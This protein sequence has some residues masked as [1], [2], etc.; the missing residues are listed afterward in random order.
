MFAIMAVAAGITMKQDLFHIVFTTTLFSVAIQGGLLPKVANKLGVV[1]DESDVRKTFNDYQEE[2]ALQLMRMYIPKG[3]NWANKKVKDVS[4]PTGSLAI[5]I[6]RED[7]TIVTKGD[8][9]I[10]P[11]DTVILSVPPYV[12]SK[13]EQLEEIVVEKEH[14]WCGKSINAL[15]LKEDELIALILRNGE[16]II[17]DGKTKIQENDV[18]VVY[19]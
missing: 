13:D 8:T 15:H 14:K 1:D 16:T 17:P 5:M 7:E 6:K 4:V 12:P 19:R 18:V 10:L 2:A 11:E 3:H 9:V